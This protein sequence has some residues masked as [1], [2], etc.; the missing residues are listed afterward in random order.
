MWPGPIVQNY[1]SG[2]SMTKTGVL[3]YFAKTPLTLKEVIIVQATI[4]LQC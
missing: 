2:I 3:A 4:G 1:Q